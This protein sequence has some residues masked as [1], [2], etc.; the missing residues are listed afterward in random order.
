[1]RIS[2][3]LHSISGP[4]LFLLKA[5]VPSAITRKA[6]PPMVSIRLVPT[7]CFM[8]WQKRDRVSLGSLDDTTPVKFLPSFF[9]RLPAAS[10]ASSRVHCFNFPSLSLIQGE[11]MRLW[12]SDNSPNRPMR[13][14]G[15][16]S[17]VS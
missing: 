17:P 9:M 1:M 13:Q 10:R 2:S 11:V 14:S 16:F 8:N 12:P 4:S 6:S 7:T 5:L 15:P 3:M